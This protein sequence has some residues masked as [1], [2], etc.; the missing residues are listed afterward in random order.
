MSRSSYGTPPKG[1]GQGS[2]GEVHT[3]KPRVSSV[4]NKIRK[5]VSTPGV[6]QSRDADDGIYT[7]GIGPEKVDARTDQGRNL[8]K[9]GY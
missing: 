2:P 8:P 9:P 3:S 4:P 5:P 1:P 6:S 7:P